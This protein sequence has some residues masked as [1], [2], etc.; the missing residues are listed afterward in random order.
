MLYLFALK[1]KGF[2]DSLYHQYPFQFMAASALRLQFDEDFGSKDL[3]MALGD[4]LRV[5]ESI[6]SQQCR[7]LGKGGNLVSST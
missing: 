2:N 3:D 5:S 1:P 7:A 4:I 6:M